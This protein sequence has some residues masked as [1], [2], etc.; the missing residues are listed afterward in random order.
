MSSTK[1]L[2]DEITDFTA[3]IKERRNAL[4]RDKDRI[5]RRQRRKETKE[6]KQT[7]KEEKD[8]SMVI[9]GLKNESHLTAA[10][11]GD[12]LT[13]DLVG[14]GQVEVGRLRRCE[15]C[16]DNSQEIGEEILYRTYEDEINTTFD[17]SSRAVYY[18]DK[19]QKYAYFCGKVCAF[20]NETNQTCH[21]HPTNCWTRPEYNAETVKICFCST[22]HGHH[23]SNKYGCFFYV[24]NNSCNPHTNTKTG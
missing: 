24:C 14:I 18:T 10:D 5:D 8:K 2:A 3:D 11:L 7:D 12:K 23:V 20:K 19:G 1:R 17:I 15:H 6:T 13:D 9:I 21:Q 16:K 22:H 4:Q